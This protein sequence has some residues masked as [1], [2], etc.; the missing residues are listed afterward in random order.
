MANPVGSCGEMIV[1]EVFQE[2]DWSLTLLQPSSRTDLQDN[3]RNTE[4]QF[5]SSS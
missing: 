5:A 2:P 3:D 4:V 1:T